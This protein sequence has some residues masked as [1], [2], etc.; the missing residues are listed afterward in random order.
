MATPPGVLTAALDALWGAVRTD[1]TELPEAHVTLSSARLST[2]HAPDRWALLDDGSLTGLRVDVDTLKAGP[3]AVLTHILH[4]AAHVLCW[5][6]GAQDVTTR[7]RY[8]NRVYLESAE[9]V[10]LLWPFEGPSSGTGYASPAPTS[11]VKL[12]FSQWLQ[13]LSPAIEDALPYLAVSTPSKRSTQ[14]ARVSISCRC[15]PPRLARMS[16]TVLEKGPIL[17][18]VCGQPFERADD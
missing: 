7:G 9:R 2:N 5:L 1:H 18:G 8:H 17:C 3:L 10:G 14:A 15:D 16:K 6:E 12:H 4:E 13:P 11:Q